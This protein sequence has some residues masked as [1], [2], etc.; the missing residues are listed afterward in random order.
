MKNTNIK[1]GERM[2]ISKTQQKIALGG[3][4]A[5]LLIGGYF[6]KNS[7]LVDQV[8]T[9]I[10]KYSYELQEKFDKSL[11]LSVG[12]VS[13][14]GI[15]S[16]DCTL[17]DLKMASNGDEFAVIKTVEINNISSL[18]TLVKHAKGD[19]LSLDIAIKGVELPMVS[20]M[21]PYEIRND[22][23]VTLGI[24]QL[25]GF[26]ASLKA[27]ADAEENGVYRNLN[28]DEFTM[29]SKGISIEMDAEIAKIDTHNQDATIFKEANIKLSANDVY[30]AIYDSYY[31]PLGESYGYRMLNRIM[32]LGTSDKIE[33]DRFKDSFKS[34]VLAEL[35]QDFTKKKDNK[36]LKAL[37]LQAYEALI[38]VIENNDAIELHAKALTDKTVSEIFKKQQELAYSGK[39]TKEIEAEFNKLVE[40]SITN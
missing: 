18:E 1:K 3:V 22:Q 23:M 26:S 32:K 27:E 35:K 7:Y 37:E 21:L 15:F 8:K 29:N 17:N 4:A 28:I 2:K 30:H 25:A 38:N 9:N 33:F 12:V 11:E 13:C 14:G 36:D 40:V 6:I 39:N 24:K 34:S 16:T 19:S 31:V 20:S 5:A 10:D